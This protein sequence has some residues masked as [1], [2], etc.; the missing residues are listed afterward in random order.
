MRDS[1]PSSWTHCTTVGVTS[2]TSSVPKTTP[3]RS[4]RNAGIQVISR[5]GAILRALQGQPDGLS[6]AE[7]SAAVKLPRSTVHRITT[8][9]AT[10]GLLESASSAGGLRI[11]PAVAELAS[12]SRPSLRDRI[13]PL[14]EDL[15]ERLGETVDLAVLDDGNE[16]RFVDQVEGPQRLSAASEIDAR[17]PLHCT[18]NGKAT[19][20]LL[21][22]KQAAKLLPARLKTFTPATTT[23]RPTLLN[24]LAAIR[25]TGIAFDREEL[26]DGICAAGFA[27][28]EPDGVTAAISVPIPTQRF[29][30]REPELERALT[31]LRNLLI[32][33]SGA[34]TQ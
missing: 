4:P 8:A 23:D 24:E 21:G 6:L 20:A 22:D 3:A 9:L 27:W 16:M 14:L 17:F 2:M 31:K 34:R 30:G 1:C 7:I 12:G 32:E 5:A 28:T 19:L 26:T 25:R 11:G 10:E 18:A 29:K 15:S 33:P 13:R